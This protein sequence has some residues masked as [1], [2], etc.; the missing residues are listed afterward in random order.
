MWNHKGSKL[1][2]QKCPHDTDSSYYVYNNIDLILKTQIKRFEKHLCFFFGSLNIMLGNLVTC[3]IRSIGQGYLITGVELYNDL[4]SETEY[5]KNFIA[6]IYALYIKLVKSDAYFAWE[7]QYT[8]TIW[9]GYLKHAF[10]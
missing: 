10:N 8:P 7:Q 9:V 5:P 4:C 2:L 3:R 1:L 6:P